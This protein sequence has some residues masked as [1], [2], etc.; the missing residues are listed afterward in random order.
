MATILNGA[1]TLV[2]PDLFAEDNLGG[3]IVGIPPL[4]T[5]HDDSNAIDDATAWQIEGF[6]RIKVNDNIEITPGVFVVTNPDF[7]GGDPIWVGTIR[8]RFSF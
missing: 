7:D 1:L 8:T 4:V 3:I 6:Y 5:S 2:F